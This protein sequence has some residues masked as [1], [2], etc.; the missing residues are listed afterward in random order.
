M[1]AN[2]A[3]LKR[4]VLCLV[5]ESGERNVFRPQALAAAAAYIEATW[6]RQ[7]YAVRRQFCDVMGILCA[8][9]EVRR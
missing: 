6:Q 4:H 9:I 8:N 7:G 1:R 5:G 3:T 2:A